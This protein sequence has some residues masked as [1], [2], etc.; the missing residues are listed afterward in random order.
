M[1]TTLTWSQ[2][3]TLA[4]LADL[5]AAWLAGRVEAHPGWAGRPDAETDSIAGHLIALN[6][7]GWLTID[8]QPGHEATEH[9]EVQRHA[10]KMIL[11]DAQVEALDHAADAAPEYL[12]SWGADL[13]PTA[14]WDAARE[15]SWAG[16]VM[17]SGVLAPG[18]RGVC[19][20]DDGVEGTCWFGVGPGPDWEYLFGDGAADLTDE[21]R[22][23]LGEAVVIAVAAPT[24]GT[25]DS[26]LWDWL[27]TLPPANRT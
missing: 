22:E 5:T 18:Q 16:P 3:R 26:G 15:W 10:V 21:L 4:D 27:R 1:T 7:S 17:V 9:G 23:A 2:A 13:I 19:P 24:W 12:L 6:E 11:T 8:S 14:A 25:D 20:A